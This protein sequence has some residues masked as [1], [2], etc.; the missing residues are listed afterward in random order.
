[1]KKKGL[2]LL[3]VVMPMMTNLSAMNPAWNDDGL[4]T[5]SE[6]SEDSKSQSSD[7][8]SDCVA[9]EDAQVDLL[10]GMD[11]VEDAELVYVPS[12]PAVFPASDLTKKFSLFECQRQTLQAYERRLIAQLNG[13][14][15]M[16]RVAREALVDE[17]VLVHND[18]CGALDEG[19]RDAASVS[20]VSDVGYASDSGSE[21]EDVS[22][23][24]RAPKP[25]TVNADHPV[26]ISDR[27]SPAEAV[28][29][30][31]LAYERR[32]IARLESGK[33]MA[34]VEREPLEDE[35]AQIQDDLYGKLDEGSDDAAASA[36]LV[37]EGGDVPD[38]AAACDEVASENNLG[39]VSGRLVWSGAEGDPLVLNDLCLNDWVVPVVRAKLTQDVDKL[40]AR[41]LKSQRAS[42]DSKLRKADALLK[43][44]DCNDNEDS[45]SPEAERACDHVFAD[46]S[47]PRA[48]TVITEPVVFNPIAISD[49]FSP[50]C[51]AR[52]ELLSYGVRLMGKMKAFRNGKKRLS[53]Y[54]K[55]ALEEELVHLLEVDLKGAVAEL[56]ALLQELRNTVERSTAHDELIY[57]TQV[58][59]DWI[60]GLDPIQEIYA[61][62]DAQE[63]MSNIRSLRSRVS[64]KTTSK[65]PRNN[66]RTRQRMSN[67][68]RARY[69]EEL[70]LIEEEY[71]MFRS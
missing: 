4:S 52:D 45:T 59:L 47:S 36:S 37:D 60:K 70:N 66:A 1:M 42:I 58:E 3:L 11:V 2:G 14:S 8:G 5:I 48:I 54:E 44:F 61:E 34:R 62:E 12:E 32:L 23:D 41:W 26:T 46:E 20:L 28:R 30:G 67:S 18:L 38:L 69:E 17:L 50:S 51:A 29:S 24:E 22:G 10:A 6:S 19:S 56:E 40:K 65:G 63:F 71:D 49:N 35:L 9:T 57:S 31:L 25:V 55:D 53:K 33:R 43:N 7:L 64:G 68:Q 13:H 16:S 39:A 21:Y 15:R 27:F